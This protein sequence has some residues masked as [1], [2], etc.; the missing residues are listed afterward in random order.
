MSSANIIRL[1]MFKA[2]DG[3]HYQIQAKCINTFLGYKRIN[4]LRGKS[5]ES[6]TTEGTCIHINLS[7]CVYIDG[8][9]LISINSELCHLKYKTKI[10]PCVNG[11]VR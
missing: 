8:T 10:V 1:M 9:V 3:K 11:C 2:E 6:S 4:T 7:L 5:A